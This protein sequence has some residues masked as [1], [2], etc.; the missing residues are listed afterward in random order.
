M[1]AIR[2]AVRASQRSP[3][4][5]LLSVTTI[6]FSLF[7]FGLFGLVA[8][9]IQET[10]TQIEERVEIRAFIADGTPIEAVSALVGDAGAFPEVQSANLVTSEEALVRAREELGEFSDIFDATILP[11]SVDVRLR[12]GF[13]DPTTVAA[14]AERLETY[15]FVDDVRYG[16]EWVEKLYRLR[17]IAGIAGLIL[18]GTFAAVAMIIIGATIRMTVLARAKEIEIMRLVGATDA[19]IRLPFL[20]EGLAKGVLGGLLALGL[21]WMAHRAIAQWVVASAFFDVPMILLGIAAG[22]ALG[23]VGSALSVGRQLRDRS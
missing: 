2:E 19:F 18:G 22:A 1:L 14:V 5:S 15:A 8:V 11:A 20:L 21:T 4:L 13:R 17:S 9:N 3:V 10:L 16:E 7:A 6:A 12:E 23:V